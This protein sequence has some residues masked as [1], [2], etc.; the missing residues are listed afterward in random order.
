MGKKTKN[1]NLLDELISKCF[2]CGHSS[3]QGGGEVNCNGCVKAE[4]IEK[5]LEDGDNLK[6]AY[7][8]FQKQYERLQKFSDKQKREAKRLKDELTRAQYE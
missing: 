8:Q 2:S 5:I 3:A 1:Q 6:K 7:K 4:V